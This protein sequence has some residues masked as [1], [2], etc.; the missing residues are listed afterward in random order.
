MD[1]Y[2]RPPHPDYC[3]YRFSGA[4]GSG[5]SVPGLTADGPGT[6]CR[7]SCRPHGPALPDAN[8]Q[9]FEFGSEPCLYRP[10]PQRQPGVVAYLCNCHPQESADGIRPARPPSLVTGAG[11]VSSAD[12]RRRA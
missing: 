9:G 2:G 6:F 8:R 1:G 5:H 3:L 7:A 12:E 4:I 10:H 11:A